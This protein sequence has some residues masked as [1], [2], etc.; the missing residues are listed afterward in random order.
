MTTVALIG[1]AG[2]A[3]WLGAVTLLVWILHA[4]EGD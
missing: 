4:I 1:L 3:T 2:Y